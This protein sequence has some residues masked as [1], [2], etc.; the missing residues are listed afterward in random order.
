MSEYLFDQLKVVRNNTL[1]AVKG[2]SENQ[3]DKIPAGFN[4]N[5]R[6]NL[7]HIYLVQER[8]AFG[9]TEIPM[10][11]P[12]GFLGLF[13]K[14]T[15]PSDWTIQPPSL[16]E[17]IKLLEDQ[18]DRIQEAFKERLDEVLA[19]PWT[20]PSGLTL[21]TVREFLTFSMYHE[22]M[23]VQAIKFLHRFGS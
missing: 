1:N 17:L 4:N 9:F 11:L 8:F 13:G 14:D 2:L 10:L 16:N 6:W 3:V 20:M 12:E 7:G 18:T 5:I 22:G 15:K 19:A 21:K 23:H